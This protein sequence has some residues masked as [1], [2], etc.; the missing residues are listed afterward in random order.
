MSPESP[1]R[2]PGTCLKALSQG[3]VPAARPRL[4]CA[5]HRPGSAPSCLLMLQTGTEAQRSYCTASEWKGRPSP[6]LPVLKPMAHPVELLGK[7]GE[8]QGLVGPPT[9]TPSIFQKMSDSL[10]PAK[11]R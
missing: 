5:F 1:F 3:P 4:R 6:G 7:G 2:K 9:Y 8:E 10:F 11:G